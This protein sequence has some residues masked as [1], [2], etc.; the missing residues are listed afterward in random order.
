M[1]RKAGVSKAAGTCKLLAFLL[2]GFLVG[3]E[4]GETQSFTGTIQW[5][6]QAKHVPSLC[7]SHTFTGSDNGQQFGVEFQSKLANIS[8]EQF[9]DRIVEI[10]GYFV[11]KKRKFNALEQQPVDTNGQPEQITCHYFSV[12][13]IR[14]V[15]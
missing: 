14:T 3:C 2:T 8:L 12:S 6:A 9:S 1:T 5:T 10:D 13:K 4:R 11:T 7:Y 15:Q